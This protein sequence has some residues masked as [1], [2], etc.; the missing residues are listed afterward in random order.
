MDDIITLNDLR[1]RLRGVRSMDDFH[2]MARDIYKN[3]EAYGIDK[4]TDIYLLFV[5]VL[6]DRIDKLEGMI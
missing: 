1:S 5:Y 4:K 6:N 2:D 3:K